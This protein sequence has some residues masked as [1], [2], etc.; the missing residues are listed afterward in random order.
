VAKAAQRPSC[1]LRGHLAFEPVTRRS[2]EHHY[3]NAQQRG[4]AMGYDDIV[5]Y[6]LDQL[7]RLAAL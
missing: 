3:A 1:G 4:A 5:A 6:S 2:V 7:D